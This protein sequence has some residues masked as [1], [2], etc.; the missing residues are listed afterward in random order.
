[1]KTNKL[2][3]R[4]IALC[5]MS[6]L[7][8]FSCK[9]DLV[10]DPEDPSGDESETLTLEATFANSTIGDFTVASWEEIDEI[11]LLSASDYVEFDQIGVDGATATFEGT[12]GTYVGAIAPAKKSKL[13]LKETQ[14]YKENAVDPAAMLLYAPVSEDAK[15]IEFK[16]LCGIV[17]VP[18]KM[19]EGEDNLESVT[20]ISNDKISGEATYDGSALVFSDEASNEVGVRA[21]F[22]G[23]PISDANGATLNIVVP[24]TTITS[25]HVKTKSG[26]EMLVE[27]NM[28]VKA[29][30]IAPAAEI[31]FK[32][33]VS[34]ELVDGV[35]EISSTSGL[36]AFRDMVNGLDN[37]T[38][39][40]VEG[41]TW[42]T[43]MIDIDAKL[44]ENIDLGGD[45]WIPIGS[46]ANWATERYT[47]TFDGNGMTISN[48]QVDIT[49]NNAG[50]FSGIY[51]GSI[52]KNL[53]LENID[54]TGNL[55]SAG[56]VGN[57]E[58]TLDA[59]PTIIENCHVL[60][61][62]VQGLKGKVGGVVGVV[63]NNVH[64]KGCSN[65]ANVHGVEARI[66][67]ITA[68]NWGT[69]MV[70]EDCHNTGKI[71][72]TAGQVGGITSF[73][74]ENAIVKD[75][76]NTGAITAE[77]AWDAG[78]LVGWSNKVNHKIINCS[79]SGEVNGICR[80]GG[81]VGCIQNSGLVA[82]CTNSGKVTGTGVVDNNNF[83]ATGGVVGACQVTSFIF[84]ASNSGAVKGG[85]DVGGVV[86]H[87]KQGSVVGACS[88]IGVVTGQRITGGVLGVAGSWE[89]GDA[90]T[91]FASY[92]TAMPK[93]ESG[94]D[95]NF[96]IVDA[97]IGN[98]IFTGCFATMDAK[99]S[100]MKQSEIEG[101]PAIVEKIDA[102]E[103]ISQVESIDAATVDAMNAAIAA[104]NAEPTN[105]ITC[106]FTFAADGTITEVP[107]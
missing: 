51:G 56:L 19:A 10:V 50:L 102:Y 64:I 77:T 36:H 21:G 98:P 82:G 37:S 3:L 95:Y 53:S 38:G 46:T 94:E 66:G 48:L 7:V 55:Q 1:M 11:V 9:E 18:V 67:G 41:A 105:V 65:A 35:Y 14:S 2:F 72:S 73:L 13:E 97:V 29:N 45:P 30:E 39:I 68:D 57:V 106:G 17:S 4:N 101:E 20:L 47:G 54:I 92:N 85:G 43:V 40:E 69:Y 58:G 16:N 86:G 107:Q 12:N 93:Q 78:G 25:I 83:S 23:L 80:V 59:D 87:F 96:G 90:P 28:T 74:G 104:Y 71:T 70:I 15:S 88:N 26:A 60:S 27:V 62:T 24:P 52:I 89:E 91:I 8:L 33:M 31:V 75:C 103:G 34:I 42:G 6:A 100:Y 84:G 5:A 81:V 99:V 44:M 76:S 79:N 61:G 32:P 22:A 63:G 49:K